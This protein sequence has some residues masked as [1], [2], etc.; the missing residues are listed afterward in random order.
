M[1]GRCPYGS[2][3]ATRESADPSA[4][5]TSFPQE[6]VGPS[7]RSR[8]RSRPGMPGNWLLAVMLAVQTLLTIRCRAD[9]LPGRGLVPV[10]GTPEMGTRSAR[11]S[12]AAFPRIPP[13]RRSST[14]RWARWP[15]ALAAFSRPAYVIL[16]MLGTTAILWFTADA[17]SA[18]E[19][20][21]SPP[22]RRPVCHHRPDT[23]SR[24]R[25][26]PMTP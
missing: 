11:C 3:A 15:T 2:R 20:R 12:A 7:R 19:R 4:R 21:S 17:S 8:R 6:T 9:T 13:G 26:P 10:G 24:A 1:T 14:S 18:G 5:V 23:A 16:F 25:S 22:P